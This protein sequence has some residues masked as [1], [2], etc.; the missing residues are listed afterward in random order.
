LSVSLLYEK[1]FHVIQIRKCWWTNGLPGVPYH[2]MRACQIQDCKADISCK[3][4]HPDDRPLCKRPVF[5]NWPDNPA[6]L[7][8]AKK[9]VH[10]GGNLAVV[11]G[12]KS[13]PPPWRLGIA[14]Y[15]ERPSSLGI[16]DFRDMKTL[17]AFTPRGYH[18]YF[19]Y[20][21]KMRMS[22]LLE[23]TGWPQPQTVRGEAMYALLPP[24]RVKGKAYWWLDGGKQEIRKL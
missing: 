9:W 18:A 22:Q 21:R 3:N 2:C 11:G 19:Y 4:C 17:V 15:D 5:K 12:P 1:G 16:S 6:S 23:K 13:A 7:S 20:K 10:E 14:D 24:S 8:E